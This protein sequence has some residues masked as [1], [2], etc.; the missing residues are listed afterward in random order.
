M[1]SDTR[2]VTEVVVGE[3]LNYGGLGMGR[4]HSVRAL[5][6]RRAAARAAFTAPTSVVGRDRVGC[7]AGGGAARLSVCLSA[8]DAALA[9]RS[10]SHSSSERNA[11]SPGL[12]R[13]QGGIT[14][15]F[16][17]L[18]LRRLLCSQ[19]PQSTSKR[20]CPGCPSPSLGPRW[21]ATQAFTFDKS[22]GLRQLSRLTPAKPVR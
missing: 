5:S 16:G 13:R 4:E 3:G 21:L 1:K 15:A 22:P 19:R 18:A 14:A 7:V 12:R 2:R 9:R 11:Q 8:S 6:W 17:Q 20:A 10:T